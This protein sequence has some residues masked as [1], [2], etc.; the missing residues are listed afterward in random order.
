M[1]CQR[2]RLPLAAHRTLASL[3]EPQAALLIKDEH[4]TAGNTTWPVHPSED[5]SFIVLTESLAGPNPLRTQTSV[6]PTQQLISR[7]SEALERFFD[8]LSA[9]TDIDLPLCG[10]CAEAV[11]AGLKVAYE[12][13]C[14]ERDAYIAFLNKIKDEPAVDGDEMRSLEKQLRQL[15]KDNE[16]ALK[17]L[18]HAEDENRK[19]QRELEQVHQEVEKSSVADNELYVKRNEQEIE[20][21]QQVTERRRLEAL[22]DYQQLQLQRLQRTN[23]YNDVFCIGYDGNFGTINGL[24]LGRLRD[25][26]VEW[27]EINGAWGQ[28]LL[29]VATM[30]NKLGIRL[31]EYRLRPLG[32]MSRIDRYELDENGNPTGKSQSFELYSSGDYSIER[33]LNHKRIDS[34]MVA[35]LDVLRQVG[36]FVE[37]ADPTLK[38]PYAIEGD[39]IGGCSIRLSLNTSNETWTAACKYVLTN[40]K[41]ILA[42]VVSH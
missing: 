13:A 42:Y 1:Q 18:K 33:L 25:K 26:K 39:K 15:E 37:N 29:L 14:A 28:T 16:V 21:Q 3:S 8:F 31:P 9:R 34:A 41:W 30:I 24:R 20:G 5:A 7:D 23:V 27:T 22:K 35:F 12:E 40:A 32:S 19:A 11:R 36:E 4:E 17:D 10:E 38:L 2:C 6:Q